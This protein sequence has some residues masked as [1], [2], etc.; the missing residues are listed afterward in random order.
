[1]RRSALTIGAACQEST[2][3]KTGARRWA[4]QAKLKLPNGKKPT[5]SFSVQ[6]F[7]DRE[8]FRLA[9]TAR[10]KMLDLVDDRPY[11]YNRMAKLRNKR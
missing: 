9:V 10:R 8:A 1:M 4:W 11:L 6:K 3:S 5:K 2:S 7:G